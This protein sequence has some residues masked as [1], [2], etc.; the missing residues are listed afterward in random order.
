[1]DTQDIRTL[2]ILEEIDRDQPPSQ[3]DLATTLNVSLG[4]VN[5]VAYYPYDRYDPGD[6]DGPAVVERS[7]SD[8]LILVLGGGVAGAGGADSSASVP[9][10]LAITWPG[11]SFPVGAQVSVSRTRERLNQL[12]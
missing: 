2:K 5:S 12:M 4:L 6:Y 11:P 1:M 9:R 10:R 7:T 3:R 8:E